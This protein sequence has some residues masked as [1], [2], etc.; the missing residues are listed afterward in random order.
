MSAIKPGSVIDDRYEIKSRL[1]SGG[2]GV[3]YLATQTSLGR[4]VAIK[5]LL[6]ELSRGP[7]ERVRFRREARVMSQL[8]HENAV[9][10]Y[11]YGDWKG[12]VFLVMELLRGMTMRDRMI[13]GTPYDTQVEILKLAFQLSDVLVAAHELSIVHR[14]LKPENVML[15]KKPDGTVRAVVVDFGLAFLTQGSPDLNRMTAENLISGTPQYM[16]P[17]QARGLAQITPAADVYALGVILWEML[18]GRPP[19]DS[20]NRMDLVNMQIFVPAE[21]PRVAAPGA[22]ISPVLDDLVLKMLE[23]SPNARP[24]AREVRDRIGDLLLGNAPRDRGRPDELVQERSRRVLTDRH[25]VETAK[26]SCD[27]ATVASDDGVRPRVFV[28]GALSDLQIMTL[29]ASGFDVVDMVVD[30]DVVWVLGG[31]HYPAST[32]V[33]VVVSHDYS[34]ADELATL[35][36]QGY[37][38]VITPAADDATIVKRLR[39]A[40][41]RGKRSKTEDSG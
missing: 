11:D 39:R 28:V 3:V 35:V 33:P 17:E 13:T 25:R 15:E 40:A 5:M 26:F 20:A 23:K 24:T 27:E 29:G 31:Y 7:E 38:E 1:G 16:A 8:R 37:A 19:F 2:M 21:A 34:S 36:R 30:A 18:V 6:P 32:E 41:R 10:V 9:E 12:R 4:D 22:D 14:D